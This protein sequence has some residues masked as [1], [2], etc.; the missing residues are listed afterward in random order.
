M[1]TLEE[2][3]L[4]DAA[5]YLVKLEKKLQAYKMLNKPV[6]TEAGDAYIRGYRK[7]NGAPFVLK[8][9]R[10]AIAFLYKHLYDEAIATGQPMTGD[11]AIAFANYNPEELKDPSNP[12]QCDPGWEPTKAYQNSIM[13]GIW[14]GN[15]GIRPFKIKTIKGKENDEEEFYD[16]WHQEWP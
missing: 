16:D 8:L 3:I 12:S 14:D 4:K 11:L 13:L 1:A 5:D 15:R 9:S 2:Q 7:Y 10:F 6:Q